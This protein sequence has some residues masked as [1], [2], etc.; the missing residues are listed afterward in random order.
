M[1]LPINIKDLLSGKIVEGE[2]MEF[3]EGWNPITILRTICAF[4]NDFENVGS[5]YIIVGV[6]ET[7]G[8]PI[9]PVKGFNPHEFEKVQQE[10]LNFCNLIQPS[11]FPRLSLESIDGKS[12]LVIWAPAGSNRP[13]KVPDDVSI[14][15][16]DYNFRIRQYSS[17]V[18]PNKE[19]E[20]EL[21]QLTAKIPFDDRV[22][23][24]ARVEAL[25]FGLM[26]E[27]LFNTHSRLFKES[28]T[29][30]VVELAMQMNLAE[31]S[32]EHLFP[33]N[34]GLL[35][36]TDNPSQYC[37]G[38]KIDVVEFPE[39]VGGAEFY[40][41]TFTGAIQKQLI[42]V[43]NYLKINVL[44][45]K[46]IK[47]PDR[48]EAAKV[49]NYPYDALEEALAN[50]V[51]HRNYE[52]P[53]PIEVRVLPHSIEIISYGGTDP[54][55]RQVDFDKGLIR[56]RRYRNRRIGEFLKE[57]K[58]TEGRGTGIPSMNRVL[59]ENGSPKAIFDTDGAERRYFIVEI[60]IHPAF[61]NG[62]NGY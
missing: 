13:Y 6:A 14:K 42:D 62:K 48:A 51:Y 49:Y 11:Y 44:K 41:K 20:I 30:D 10:L 19:Q 25:N 22:N 27:H 38:A 26:R 36:F 54:S 21:I 32:S 28:M 57:L 7:E 53:E 40:E 61:K 23:F 3:K 29:M 31:G 33:K 52:L 5:G 55:V 16:K 18:I 60:P 59:L 15:K 50:A 1:S 43:L 12:V 2:R 45:S 24:H 34:I 58:L 46:V 4:A 17:S 56:A 39:G 35:M 47:F 9:R 37:R 8:R